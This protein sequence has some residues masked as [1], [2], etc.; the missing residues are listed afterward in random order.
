M[1]AEFGMFIMGAVFTS[2]VWAIQYWQD[3]REDKRRD[4]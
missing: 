2:V 1:W 3:L 4:D